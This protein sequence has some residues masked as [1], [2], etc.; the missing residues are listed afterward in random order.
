MTAVEFE[1]LLETHNI[2]NIEEI[3]KDKLDVYLQDKSN[4][5]N[6]RKITLNTRMVWVLQWYRSILEE[7]G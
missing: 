1:E 7:E 2:D 5:N 6:N 3:G 4:T